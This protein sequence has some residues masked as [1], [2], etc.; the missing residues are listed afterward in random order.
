MRLYELTDEWLSL[1]DAMDSEDGSIPPD[2]AER[3]A[4][5]EGDIATKI[6][7]CCKVAKGFAA[8]AEAFKTEAERLRKKSTGAARREQWLKDYI[9]E[10]LEKL[11]EKKLV[12]GLFTVAIQNSPISLDV[13]DIDSVP[14][15]YDSDI[16]PD[17]K[18][19]KKA[20][21]QEFKYGCDVPGCTLHQ[22]THLRIR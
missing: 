15:D 7:G 12:A 13:H 11:G 16:Q 4:R 10:Q 18:L 20:I 19:D 6:E 21:L 5:I 8:A 3:M 22:N 2:L 9:K 14:D 1:I 17:R